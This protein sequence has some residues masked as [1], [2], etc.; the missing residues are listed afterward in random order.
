[1]D[2]ATAERI[3]EGDD[4]VDVDRHDAVGADDLEELGDVARGHR[5]A[6]LGLPVLAGVS[7]VGDD[8][9]DPRRAV[10]LAGGDEEQQL[11][12][13]VVGR[14]AVAAGE[15]VDDV[16]VLAAHADE[17]T[18][19]VLAVLEVALLVAFDLGPH[20]PGDLVA[21]L[22]R[23]LQGEDAHGALIPASARPVLTRVNA[24]GGRSPRD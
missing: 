1:M 11:D 24:A 15:A 12:Q 19:L 7:E 13:L 9:G 10:L 14:G 2:G 8:R 18:R 23:S 4:V 22:F 3:L 6:G 16:D 21:E 20:R 5:V 17:R